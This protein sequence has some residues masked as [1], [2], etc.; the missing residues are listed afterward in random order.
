[1]C[2]NYNMFKDDEHVDYSAGNYLLLMFANEMCTR[3]KF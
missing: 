1:M 3:V 2:Y